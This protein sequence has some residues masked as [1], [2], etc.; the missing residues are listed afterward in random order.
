MGSGRSAFKDATFHP[1]PCD[2]RHHRVSGV[3]PMGSGMPPWTCID[4]CFGSM[5]TV[6]ANLLATGV[7]SVGD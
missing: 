1:L 2:Y 4:H 6:C 3:V 5:C 7:Q